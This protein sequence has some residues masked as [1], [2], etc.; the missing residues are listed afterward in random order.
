MIWAALI[1]SAA[2][3]A[4]SA[5]AVGMAFAARNDA[6]ATRGELSRHRHSHALRR[7]EDA[8]AR[9]HGERPGPPPPADP[10]AALP[11]TEMGV[12]PPPGARRRVRDDPQA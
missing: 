2:A 5:V 1:L 8:P 4:L 11:T 9:R 7:A 6:S 3:V 10:D 12:L